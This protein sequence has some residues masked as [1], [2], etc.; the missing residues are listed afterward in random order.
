MTRLIK[1]RLLKF[2]KYIFAPKK[3]IIIEYNYTN[4]PLLWKKNTKHRLIW[5]HKLTPFCVSQCLSPCKRWFIYKDDFNYPHMFICPSI[6]RDDFNYPH[7]FI[8]PSI[9]KVDFNY[10]HMFICL[11]LLE[12]ISITH[13]FIYPSIHKDDFNY[14]IKS[15]TKKNWVFWKG[16]RRHK[17]AI[18][19]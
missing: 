10:P 17:A 5:V 14:P 19:K 2:R 7:M 8:C 4:A 12:M 16:L 6:S 18:Q 1:A 9:Y 15:L 3:M 11:L 13:M